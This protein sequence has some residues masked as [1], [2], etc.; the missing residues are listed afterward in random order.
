MQNIIDK[1]SN[2]LE[3]ERPTHAIPSQKGYLPVKFNAVNFHEIKPGL[4]DLNEAGEVAFIDGGNIEIIGN[5]NFSLQ[6]M[7][8]YWAKYMGDKRIKA[9]K[10]DYFVLI[11]SIVNKSI[12]FKIEVFDD[13]FEKIE[14]NV[15]SADNEQKPESGVNLIRRIYEI[16]AVK[17]ISENLNKGIIVL[18]G[19][20]SSTHQEEEEELK[21]AFNTVFD[22]DIVLLGITKSSSAVTD[23]G[24]S[25][26]GYLHSIAEKD[27]WYYHPLFTK[28][29]SKVD[30]YV[31]KL[32]PRS[33]FA[34][35]V[36]ISKP[37]DTAVVFNTLAYHAR[38]PTFLGYPYGLLEADRSAR[39]QENEKDHLRIKF[40]QHFKDKHKISKILNTNKAHDVLDH[41]S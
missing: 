17:E 35:M 40:M 9:K 34:F 5:N 22:K 3:G 18:D 27:A 37:A 8:T 26:V 31:A 7:R 16:R 24:V 29:G 33:R 6:L 21:K 23:T 41:M 39:C 10:S 4:F 28:G 30:L 15:V 14:E 20:L 11:S 25:L 32:H 36:D 1:I 2:I 12:H 38:D 19:N 13:S